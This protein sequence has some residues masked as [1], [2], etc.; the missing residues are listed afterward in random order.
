L[1]VEIY[2]IRTNQ[3]LAGKLAGRLLSSAACQRAP[4]AIRTFLPA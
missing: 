1:V 2:G 3:F 4:A